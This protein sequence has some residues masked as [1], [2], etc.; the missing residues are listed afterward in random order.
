[1][2]LT[3]HDT[4]DSEDTIEVYELGD[5]L[6]FYATEKIGCKTVNTQISLNKNAQIE[7][8]K[9]LDKYLFG[10]NEGKVMESL[11]PYEKT[12][13]RNVMEPLEPYEKTDDNK[14]MIDARKLSDKITHD[15]N[16]GSMITAQ[17]VVCYLNGYIEGKKND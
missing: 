7:L 12:G 10:D 2:G 9:A 4:I 17:E 13:D 16:E 8:Y 6:V 14:V 3:L 1:M 11:E 15:T 5:T